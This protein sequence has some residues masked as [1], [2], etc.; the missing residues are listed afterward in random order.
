MPSRLCTRTTTWPLHPCLRARNAISIVTWYLQRWDG[1]QK[2]SIF[3][4]RKYSRKMFEFRD[5]RSGGSW[6]EKLLRAALE[7]F[8]IYRH[9]H[10]VMDK[11]VADCSS[12]LTKWGLVPHKRSTGVRIPVPAFFSCLRFF[13]QGP[14]LVA[15]IQQFYIY[16]NEQLFIERTSQV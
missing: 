1:T 8:G 9:S 10:P 6:G 16:W 12:W 4:H 11:L 3:S 7:A 14:C 2:H 13:S 15:R 5:Q